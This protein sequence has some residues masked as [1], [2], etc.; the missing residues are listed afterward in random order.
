MLAIGPTVERCDI[1]I[2]SKI[3]W[4]FLV[5]FDPASLLGVCAATTAENFGG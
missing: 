2:D 4:P 3:Q 1:D 5:Q